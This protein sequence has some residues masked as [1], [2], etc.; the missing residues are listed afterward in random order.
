MKK[1]FYSWAFVDNEHKCSYKDTYF[2]KRADEVADTNLS[3]VK[4][5]SIF[6]SFIGIVVIA[7]AFTFFAAPLLALIYVMII[8]LEMIAYACAAFIC[9]MK[10]RVHASYV[11]SSIYLFHMLLISSILGTV[12]STKESALVFAVILVIS[13][14]I[15]VM[16]PILTTCMGSLSLALTFVL[17][18]F[19]KTAEYFR[20]DILNCSCVFLLSILIGWKIT[21]I[22]VEEADSRN[23]AIQLSRELENLSMVDQLTNLGNHR[24][25]Q[26]KYYDLYD[27]LRN[28]TGKIGIIMMDIDKFK[29][30]NDSYGHLQ[31]DDCLRQVGECFGKLQNENV[32]AFRFGGEEFVV[33]VQGEECSNIREIAEAYRKSIEDRAIIH[34][35][36]PVS[37]V[38]T[39]SVGVCLES[40]SVITLPMQLVD[41]AD[42]ALYL[43][44][45]AGGNT[46][47]VC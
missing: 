32:Q 46:V 15:F 35:Y 4:T 14:I 33:I 1:L 23:R 31:G 27:E 10:R 42:R 6:I 43:S 25:F 39:I 8:C 45:N 37:N 9:K 7:M 29:M 3:M 17:S 30:Y 19:A 38:V 2:G 44:K 40:P 20:T 36:S 11:L 18:Y 47:T 24:S 22:R 5:I 34:E 41:M 21:K 26:K 28:T 16:P 12:Y 13:Q